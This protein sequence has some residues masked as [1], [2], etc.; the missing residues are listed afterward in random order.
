MV[1]VM[2]DVVAIIHRLGNV[3]VF[4]LT[5]IELELLAILLVLFSIRKK[6]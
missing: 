2:D 5:C 4:L 6:L 3:V 1:P